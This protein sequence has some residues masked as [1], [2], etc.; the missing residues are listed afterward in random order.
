MDVV[1]EYDYKCGD[2]EWTADP[3]GKQIKKGD[4]V[5]FNYS[6]EVRLGTIIE[7]REVNHYGK[8]RPL[9]VVSHLDI[10]SINSKITN[11]RNMVVL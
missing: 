9:F 11:S 1:K 5:A 6:G 3:Y 10:P 7:V 8:V 4:R 2:P